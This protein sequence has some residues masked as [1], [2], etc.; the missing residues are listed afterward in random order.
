MVAEALLDLV[1]AQLLAVGIGGHEDPPH[2]R[3]AA[4]DVGEA[5]PGHHRDG[6]IGVDPQRVAAQGDLLDAGAGRAFR[7][8]AEDLRAHRGQAGLEERVAGVEVSEG[9][10]R[11]RAEQ[12]HLLVCGRRV[13]EGEV[14][15]RRRGAERGRAVGGRARGAGDAVGPEHGCL[16]EQA[17]AGAPGRRHRAEAGGRLA[18]GR[19]GE[20]GSPLPGVPEL[21]VGERGG[22]EHR[23]RVGVDADGIVG[24]ERGALVAERHALEG[25]G[26]AGLGGPAGAEGPEAV[27]GDAH[28]FH[29]VAHGEPGHQRRRG[30]GRVGVPGEG[31]VD[32]ALR[33][34]EVPGGVQ[35][36]QP[37]VVPVPLLAERVLLGR[38]DGLARDEGEGGLD[39]H[40]QRE[41]PRLRLP[42]D[43]A[44]GERAQGDDGD[45][46]HRDS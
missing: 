20:R 6:A 23:R 7:G 19:V 42:E 8:G 40:R 31:D 26:R 33:R 34:G 1:P 12:L 45:H 11:P 21:E 39:D 28:R 17:P 2:P 5:A 9:D 18:V 41:L 29:Q 46:A 35:A 43:R 4:P 15:A 24:A 16:V 44:R 22:A 36:G 3:G 25:R 14:E 38:D 32:A 13:E 37:V 27:A 30:R 10:G